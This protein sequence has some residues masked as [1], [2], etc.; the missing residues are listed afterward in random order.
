MKHHHLLFYLL[1][2]PL[3]GLYW[4][5][6]KKGQFQSFGFVGGKIFPQGFKIAFKF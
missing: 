2:F 4:V 1:N 3:N 6:S 5:S